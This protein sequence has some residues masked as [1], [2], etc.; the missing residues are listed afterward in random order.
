MQIHFLQ[1]EIKVHNLHCGPIVLFALS[2]SL[3]LHKIKVYLKAVEYR[4]KNFAKCYELFRRTINFLL[5]GFL[6][7]HGRRVCIINW[8]GDTGSEA[9]SCSQ[10]CVA[11]KNTHAF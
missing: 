10:N 1:P 9:S 7:N 8:L 4:E 3:E 2:V 5:V 11:F 6:S